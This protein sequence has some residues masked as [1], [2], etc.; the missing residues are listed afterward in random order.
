MGGLK[1]RKRLDLDHSSFCQ[2]P[3][4]YN[5][6]DSNSDTGAVSATFGRLSLPNGQTFFGK[7][8]GRYCDGRLIIDFVAEKLGL[9]YLSAY[10]DS[11]GANF[12][13]GANFAASGSSIQPADSAILKG[14]VNPLSLNIQLLQF[15][16]FKERT[17]ELYTEAKNSYHKSGLPRPEDFSKALY[18][19]DTGQNDLHAGI[20]SMRVEEVQKHIPNIINEFSLNVKNL[21]QLGARTFWI[22]NTGPIGCLPFF[23]VNYPPKAGNSDQNGCVKSYNDLAQEFN[24]QLKD[25]ISQLRTQ[26]S[27]VFITYVDIYSVKYALISEAKK[28]GFSGPLGYCCGHYGDYRARCGRKSLVNGTELYGTSCEK[29]AEYLSWD[30]IHYSEAANKL[31]ADQILDGSFSDPSIAISEACHRPL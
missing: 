20:T 22:H 25:K 12:R 16:Q 19:M 18:T 2:F 14:H 5:F 15:E 21:H 6:G 31:V 3:A 24:R 27:D 7:P 9:P 28:Y 11:I 13:H 23:V 26:L 10:L 4:I 1:S 8:A 30:G 29:P 17:A